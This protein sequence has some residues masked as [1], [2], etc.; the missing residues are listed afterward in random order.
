MM[1]QTP[2]IQLISE[3][4]KKIAEQ[5]LQ[6]HQTGNQISPPSA[7]KPKPTIIIAYEDSFT[8]EPTENAAVPLARQPG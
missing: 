2:L 1:S 6:N 4:A 3:V 7:P 5:N 8:L